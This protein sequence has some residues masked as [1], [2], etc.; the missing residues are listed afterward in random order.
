MKNSLQTLECIFCGFH[1]KRFLPGGLDLPVLK[2]LSVVGAGHRNNKTCPKCSSKDRERLIYLYLKTKTHILSTN[3]NIKLLHI[4]PE[5]ELSRVLLSSKNTDYFSI[6]LNSRQGSEK[7]DIT[8]L[9]FNDN[10]FDVIICLH[11]LE[12]V[13]NDKKAMLEVFRVLKPGG[14]AILQVPLSHKIKNSVEDPTITDP[15][16][17]EQTFGQSDHVRIYSMHDYKQRLTQTGFSLNIY[18]FTNE[19]GAKLSERYA[20]VKNE[21]VYVCKKP[22]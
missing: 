20:L 5:K 9:K 14:M 1:S 6:D 10:F 16:S 2:K 18:N 21:D 11:V 12:H 3:E 7:M 22:N 4:A 15:K 17:R 8:N 13:I 19:F